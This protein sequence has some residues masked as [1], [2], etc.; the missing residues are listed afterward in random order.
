MSEGYG[1]F[2]LAQI[3]NASEVLSFE[4]GL[5]RIRGKMAEIFKRQKVLTIAINASAP[6]IGS[7]NLSGQIAKGLL[8]Q[9]VP[10]G[11]CPHPDDFEAALHQVGHF[12]EIFENWSQVAYIIDEWEVPHGVRKIGNIDIRDA[13]DDRLRVAATA[14]GLPLKK[15]DLWVAIFTKAS[16]FQNYAAW[17][18]DVYDPIEDVIICN[19]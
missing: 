11:I 18:D 4:S 12:R 8:E 13:Y 2:R 14:F 1:F 19:D 15:V 3:N 17:S 10:T 16:P 6:S 9:G 5:V 7:P